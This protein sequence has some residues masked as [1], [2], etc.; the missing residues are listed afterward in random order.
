MEEELEDGG[1]RVGIKCLRL[2]KWAGAFSF[3]STRKL[4]ER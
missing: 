2:G 1:G 4:F 3:A